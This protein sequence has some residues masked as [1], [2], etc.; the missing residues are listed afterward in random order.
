[1]TTNTKE[2]KALV[3]NYILNAIDTEAYEVQANTEAEKLQF[4]ADTFKKE[5]GHEVKRYG[6]Y[7]G[8]LAQWFMGL[9]S[10]FN[11]D[12]EN[13]RII[14]IAKEWGSLPA[15]AT[16]KQ[17]DKIISN[18]FNFIAAKTMQLMSKHN[19]YLH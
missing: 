19:I 9:P 14:E 13:Y 10:V 2:F 3:N 17:E 6:N 12:F 1:M 11:V 5:Y 15:N 7:Q 16:E 4:L 18:W 8:T